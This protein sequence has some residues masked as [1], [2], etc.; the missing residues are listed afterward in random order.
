MNCQTAKNQ[1][2]DLVYPEGPANGPLQ[3][4]VDHCESCRSELRELVEAKQLLDCFERDPVESLRQRDAST[5]AVSRKSGV[6]GQTAQLLAMGFAAMLGAIAGGMFV[7]QFASEISPATEHT[8]QIVALETHL[9]DVSRQ[10]AALQDAPKP[11]N[12]QSQLIDQQQQ[13]IARLSAEL[14]EMKRRQ[15]ESE[16]S[17]AILRD[18]M[19]FFGSYVARYS[20]R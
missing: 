13:S 3:Q 1:L 8:A 12:E 9:T 10:L 5:G 4:H 18:D 16:L 15:K 17:L 7:W 6:W 20:G 11:D 14:K 19:K 2:I